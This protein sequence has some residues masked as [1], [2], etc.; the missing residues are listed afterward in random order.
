MISYL[1][2]QFFDQYISIWS[3]QWHFVK[4]EKIIAEF[5]KDVLQTFWWKRVKC[6]HLDMQHNEESFNTYKYLILLIYSDDKIHSFLKIIHKTSY[7][8]SEI[9]YPHIKHTNTHS[10]TV[11]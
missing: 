5:I 11:I 2:I 9:L 8:Y 3:D 4:P 10:K 7:M 6:S 1:K